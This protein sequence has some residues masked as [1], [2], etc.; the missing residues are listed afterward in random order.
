[1]IDQFNLLA[2]LGICLFLWNLVPCSLDLTDFTTC[3]DMT[4]SF[5]LPRTDEFYF[6]FRLSFIRWERSPVHCREFLCFSKRLLVLPCVYSR[7]IL[8]LPPVLMKQRAGKVKRVM[9]CKWGTLTKRRRK[10]QLKD[11]VLSDQD[12]NV[13]V[14]WILFE[15]ILHFCFIIPLQRIGKGMRRTS[16]VELG[17]LQSPPH[18]GIWIQDE[19][20]HANIWNLHQCGNLVAKVLHWKKEINL[21]IFIYLGGH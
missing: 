11:F 1:M 8:I 21:A 2:P 4:W 3:L 19:V 16:D 10:H 5:H 15:K 12:I 7:L 20:F 9:A 6:D 18:R 17:W 13:T 14:K